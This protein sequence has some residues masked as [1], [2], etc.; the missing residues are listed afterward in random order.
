M[1][2]CFFGITLL[3]AV[4]C[5]ADGGAVL[6]RQSIKGLGLTVFASPAALLPDLWMAL[7]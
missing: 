3:A 2:P 5:H 4:G 7:R 6:A 1:L